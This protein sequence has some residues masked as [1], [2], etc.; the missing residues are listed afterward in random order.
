MEQIIIA[1]IKKAIEFFYDNVNYILYFL[2]ITFGWI[3]AW[4][5][6]KS[7]YRE[8]LLKYPNERSSHD[9]VTPTG[10]GIGILITLVLG[11]MVLNI[12]TTFVF[13]AMFVSLVSFYDDS[14]ELSA[15]FR[16]GNHFIAAILLIIPNLFEVAGLSI[17]HQ[18]L[19]WIPILITVPFIFFVVATANFY[20][21]MDGI[22]GIAGVTGVIGFGLIILYNNLFSYPHT[23]IDSK[24]II[25]AACLAFS[26]LGFLPLNMPRA[27]V[28]MGDVGSILLGFVFAGIVIK[29]SRNFLDFICMAAFL[30]PFYAD[31]LTTIWVRLRDNERLTQSHRRHLYQ[32]LANEFQMAHWKVTMLYGFAQLIV[33]LSIILIRNYGETIIVLL[34]FFYFAIFTLISF[35]VRKKMMSLRQS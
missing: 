4:Y 2:S 15:R 8:R 19:Y 32:I 27:K 31:E 6:N 35:Y 18:H 3:G 34:L 20:N 21:F 14:R 11:C 29:L 22:N 12:M 16:L 10:G 25:I 9:I 1:I 30:F 13:P 24:F 23:L 33:G 17:A 26:C 28:F 7:A 5:I